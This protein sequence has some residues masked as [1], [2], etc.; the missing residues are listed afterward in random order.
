MRDMRDMT[1][2]GDEG[3]EGDEGG[4]GKIIFRESVR[5]WMGDLSIQSKR[6]EITEPIE[7]APTWPQVTSECFLDWDRADD[8]T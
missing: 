3:D 7:P 5:V 6:K 8:T 1:Y 4:R 2:E